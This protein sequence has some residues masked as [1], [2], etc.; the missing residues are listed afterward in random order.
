MRMT[1][2]PSKP[3]KQVHIISSSMEGRPPEDRVYSA[4]QHY[5]FSSTK[6]PGRPPSSQLKLLSILNQNPDI[7]DD[8]I[9][10]QLDLKSA[11][12]AAKLRLRLK[13]N[14]QRYI[15]LEDSLLKLLGFMLAHPEA[16]D[17]LC[18]NDGDCEEERWKVERL[19]Q[20]LKD[21]LEATTEVCCFCGKGKTV[22]D[23]G[24]RVCKK[25]G[26][27]QPHDD[28]K[29][30]TLY[31]R[32]VQNFGVWNKNL[33]TDP[34]QI[35][36]IVKR[37]L[38][39]K[40]GIIIRNPTD[41][42]FM[43]DPEDLILRDLLGYFTWLCTR[44]GL[45]PYVISNAAKILRR[46]HHRKM[47]ELLN[48]EKRQ[49]FALLMKMERL[50]RNG[51]NDSEKIIAVTKEFFSSRDSS[52]LEFETED[53]MGWFDLQLPEDLRSPSV[54]RSPQSMPLLARE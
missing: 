10:Q 53:L 28:V 21:Y 4:S 37:K 20:Y 51:V 39:V 46:H 49:A 1:C 17:Q 3:V 11:K 19:K 32:Q 25:C 8:E 30:P 16:V 34:M 9:A 7:T 29:V 31:Y 41:P 45:P 14:R 48:L 42:R 52:S 2:L 22:F 15:G 18:G 40:D 6:F 26:A 47:R 43:G 35:F 38:F 12:D 24:E 50:R 23:S 54:R 27:V 13:K 5:G 33:G 44:A 36:N